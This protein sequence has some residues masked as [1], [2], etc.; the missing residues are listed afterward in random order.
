[1]IR[2]QVSLTKTE[3]HLAKEAAKS[4]GV[5]LAELLRRA[6]AVALPRLAKPN[7]RSRRWMSY[8]GLIASGDSKSS[9]TIDDVIYGQKD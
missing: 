5:S 1:M 4:L 2:T 9:Q 6:L 8:E 7:A 3:Y